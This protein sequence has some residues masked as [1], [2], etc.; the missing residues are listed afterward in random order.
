MRTVAIKEFYS[1]VGAYTNNCP[2][3][4]IERAVLDTINDMC[5]KTGRLVTTSCFV[6]EPGRSTYSFNLSPEFRAETVRHMYCGGKELRPATMDELA[7][8]Y[9]CDYTSAEGEPSFYFFRK[10]YEIELVPKPTSEQHV[11][12]DLTVSVS[13]RSAHVPEEFFTSMADAVVNGA[14]SRILSI[15]G[16][17]FSNATLAEQYKIKYERDLIGI[18]SDAMAGF[19]RTTGRVFFNRI[20]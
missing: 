7:A 20:V 18:K 3:F 2:N 12:I 16:Q 6:T 8:R 9:S 11:R 10:P 13:P 5:R 1:L 15:A 14:L 17:P 4:V 19:Q